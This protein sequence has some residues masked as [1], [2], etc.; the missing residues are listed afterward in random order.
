MTDQERKNLNS[1]INLAANQ[2]GV[3]SSETASLPY[4]KR[5]QY[6]KTLAGIIL[7][8][9]T[10]F[11]AQTITNAQ[12]AMGANYQPMDTYGFGEMVGDF[13]DEAGNQAVEIGASVA[14]VGEGVKNTLNLSKYLLPVGALVAAVILLWA[15]A[16]RTGAAK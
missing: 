10:R 14:A 11:D 12:K 8:Y 5:I 15:F 7:Q 16:R 9:P 4:E 6:L 1:A 2:Y 3:S 13:V